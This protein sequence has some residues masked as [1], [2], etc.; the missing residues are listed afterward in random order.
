M[1]GKADRRSRRFDTVSNFKSPAY[2]NSHRM[3]ALEPRVLLSGS[4]VDSVY[5]ADVIS[6][7]AV[8]VA[9]DGSVLVTN[10]VEQVLAELARDDRTFE[11][12]QHLR[13]IDETDNGRFVLVYSDWDA[14]DDGEL[15]DWA[16]Q[17]Y[18]ID[19]VSGEVIWSGEGWVGAVQQNDLRGACV[20][21]DGRYIV[22]SAKHTSSP[23]FGHGERQQGFIH[24]R[25]T[26]TTTLIAVPE[27]WNSH[28]RFY[29]SDD[30]GTVYFSSQEQTYIY[31]TSS[32]Q[33][34]ALTSGRLMGIS[35]N[36][37]FLLVQTMNQKEM[38]VVDTITGGVEVIF[39]EGGFLGPGHISEDGRYVWFY[40]FESNL[41]GVERPGLSTGT[42]LYD[43]MT[44]TFLFV[45]SELHATFT[46]EGRFPPTDPSDGPIEIPAPPELEAPVVETP[47]VP[48]APPVAE[49]IVEPETE[50]V[51]T[52]DPA[53]IVPVGEEPESGGVGIP[54]EG[55]IVPVEWE[56]QPISGPALIDA[57]LFPLPYFPPLT[58]P[59][60]SGVDPGVFALREVVVDSPLDRFSA[61]T[62]GDDDW[63][64]RDGVKHGLE[65]SV[66]DIW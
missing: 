38:K 53:P 43:R 65:V 20:S 64:D 30:G 22:F 66:G 37:R 26:G 15:P 57:P 11:D 49:P 44:D 12:T 31:D 28:T 34:T 16:N 19:R 39:D 48:V 32:N 55:P 4:A 13:L 46:D 63:L 5:D 1:P 54:V 59:K 3:E 41:D 51:A 50:P 35:E 25:E 2:A 10:G 62:P 58:T 40:S 7:A 23:G 18:L 8:V 61:L 29:M 47:E 17:L 9:D 36:G 52:P 45:D 33:I 60:I 24:D 56:S 6:V 42:W 21:E 14:L 27:G